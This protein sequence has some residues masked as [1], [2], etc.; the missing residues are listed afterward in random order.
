MGSGRPASGS[1]AFEALKS[2]ELASRIEVG[3]QIV[4]QCLRFRAASLDQISAQAV[5]HQ[6]GQDCR[7][8]ETLLLRA[9]AMGILVDD[10]QLRLHLRKQ[11]E[12]SLRRGGH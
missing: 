9:V 1:V 3:A 12:R 7:S 4:V 8:L 5:D 11:E 10:I 6:F 2:R